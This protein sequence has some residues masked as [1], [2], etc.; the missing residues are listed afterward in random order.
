ML[1]KICIFLVVFFLVITLASCGGGIFL[2]NL[3][4]LS[5]NKQSS[6]PPSIGGSSHAQSFLPA[7]TISANITREIVSPKRED[8]FFNESNEV[9]VVLIKVT[10]L[11]KD[12]LKNL[13]IWEI[14]GNGLIIENCSYPLKTSSIKDL[15]DYG[16]SDNHSFRPKIYTI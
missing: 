10:S 9:I 8:G 6:S 16:E 14:P 2:N 13:E 15:L 4:D 12:G 5:N 7:E 11:K 1:K 3:P